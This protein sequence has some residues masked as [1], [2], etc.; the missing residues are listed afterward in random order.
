M[1]IHTLKTLFLACR[2]GNPLEPFSCLNVNVT[3]NEKGV[4]K[5]KSLDL[6]SMAHVF[7][8]AV[9]QVSCSSLEGL[10]AVG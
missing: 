2:F 1:N 10:R 8:S 5:Q 3:C 6:F 4:Y 7:L 9:R